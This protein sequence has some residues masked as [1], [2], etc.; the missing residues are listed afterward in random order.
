MDTHDSQLPP[1]PPAGHRLLEEPSPVAEPPP[2]QGGPGLGS[3]PLV[4]LGNFAAAGVC[5]VAAYEILFLAAALLVFLSG[6]LGGAV[7]LGVAY[8]LFFVVLATA[9]IPF[10]IWFHRAYKGLRLHGVETRF[11]PGWAIGCWFVPFA[12]WVL[13]GMIGDEIWRAGRPANEA[14]RTGSSWN[15]ARVWWALY[16]GSGLFGYVLLVAGQFTAGARGFALAMILAT[17]LLLLSAAFAIAFVRRASE[18]LD[19]L[20]AVDAPRDGLD[21]TIASIYEALPLPAALTDTPPAGRP[22]DGAVPAAPLSPASAPAGEPDIACTRCG[23]VEAPGANFC[24][25]CGAPV[26]GMR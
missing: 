25:A 20:T 22:N 12:N 6:S 9:G 2:G 8:L 7:A 4:R 14:V 10:I 18:R 23:A 24:G 15:L 17:I 1:P 5:T 3:E 26:G 21:R 13:P 19:A 11:S 16:I